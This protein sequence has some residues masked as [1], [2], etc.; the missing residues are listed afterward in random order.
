MFAW[1]MKPGRRW[2]DSASAARWLPIAP[3]ARVRVADQ[4]R[5]VLVALGEQARELRGV[6]QER[7][8]GAG[9]PRQLGEDP[10]RGREERVRVVKAP[11]R[12]FGD[13]LIGVA[14]ALHDPLE[15]LDRLLVEGVEDLVQVDRGD[16]LR[17]AQ[18]AAVCN[19]AALVAVRS[20]R[21]QGEL[22]L[23][24]GD[25]R[26]RV[27]AH[28]RDRALGE[29]GELL[30][31]GEGD[32]GLAVVAQL[33]L[34]DEPGGEAADHH[35]VAVHELARVLELG[36]Y[37]VLVTAVSEQQDECDGGDRNRRD[38]CDTDGSGRAAQCPTACTFP[39]TAP[40]PRHC[41][42]NYQPQSRGVKR[43]PTPG[44]PHSHAHFRPPSLSS[45]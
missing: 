5:D 44:K 21:R 16:R 9:V 30:V 45:R 24:P 14:K 42:R 41:G 35:L 39:L 4:L 2:I 17:L 32:E 27:L 6:D 12:L 13:S 40:A 20:R 10:P 22:D 19:L 38:R 25:R 23:A 31:D 34:L 33:D 7:L 1:R 15:V 37:A 43:E 36:G 8:E 18:G 29:G 11:V 28:G 3:S 26:E